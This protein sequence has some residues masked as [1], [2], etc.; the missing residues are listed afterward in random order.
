MAAANYRKRPIRVIGAGGEQGSITGVPVSHREHACG[1][2]NQTYVT[3]TTH[4]VAFGFSMAAGAGIP[5][6]AVDNLKIQIWRVS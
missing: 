4:L 5:T 1:F 3:A 2:F 6:T